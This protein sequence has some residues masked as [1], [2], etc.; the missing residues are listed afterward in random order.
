MSDI[1]DLIVSEEEK[2]LQSYRSM[3][4]IINAKP[5][6]LMKTYDEAVQVEVSDIEDLNKRILRKIRNHYQSES[7]GFICTVVVNFNDRT[8]LD[9]KCWEEF[10]EH[11]WYENTS[12][13]SIIIKWKFTVS[14]PQYKLPQDHTIVVKLSSSLR[15]D[16]IINLLFSGTIENIDEVDNLKCPVI[17]RVDYVDALLANEIINIISG[18]VESLNHPKRK[19]SKIIKIMCSNRKFIAQLMEYGSTIFSGVLA[20]FILSKLL[21]TL[22]CENV[23]SMTIYNLQQ[24]LMVILCGV[25]IIWTLNKFSHKFA[26]ITYAK[27]EDYGEVFTFNISRGDEKIQS[28]VKKEDGSS[29][30]A[31]CLNIISTIIFNLICIIISFM[32]N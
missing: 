7:D 22:E 25:L 8:T 10:R 17:A 30:K 5:D 4:N 27:L 20:F 29:L 26:K 31:I 11:N 15:L 21:F 18:W 13:K 6:S 2:M 14:I 23:G 19:E 12:I 1:S 24:V 16:E 3:F 9:L 32:L 28:E